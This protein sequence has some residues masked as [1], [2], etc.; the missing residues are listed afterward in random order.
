MHDGLVLWV[1]TSQDLLTMTLSIPR[2]F[3]CALF[4]GVLAFALHRETFYISLTT[5]NDGSDKGQSPYNQ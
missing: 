1:W 3:G 5:L 4:K 2:V